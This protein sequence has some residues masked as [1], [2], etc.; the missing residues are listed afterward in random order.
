MSQFVVIGGGIA[1]LTAAN[2]LAS[3]GAQVTIFEQAHELGGRA[4]T[5]QDGDYF[6]NL[7]PHALYAGGVA[8]RTFAEWDVPFSGGNPTQEVE[9]M[10]AVLVRG[11]ELFP[12]VTDL[13][14]ILASRLFSF[15][16][17]V[18]LARLFVSFREVDAGASKNFNQWLDEKVGSERVRE[19]IRMVVRT[20]TYAVEFDYLSARSA[21]RQLSLALKPG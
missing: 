5:R 2:A 21:L 11:D 20:A 13:R 7:G 9:G 3:T 18:E 15:R 1:G 17:K 19:F 12:A 10:R 16:E 6:L 14:S 8:A 4:R